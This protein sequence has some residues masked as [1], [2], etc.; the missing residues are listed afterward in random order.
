MSFDNSHPEL[1]YLVYTKLYPDMICETLQ[2]KLHKISLERKQERKVD[3]TA[4]HGGRRCLIE[5]QL[6]KS[7]KDHLKQV[8]DLIFM[9]G[10]GNTLLVW[11]AKEFKEHD[12][13]EIRNY[14]ALANGRNIEFVALRLNENIIKMVEQINKVNLFKQIEMLG[15]LNSESHF[16]YVESIKNYSGNGTV[17][18]E[19]IEDSISYTRKQQVLLMTI[20]ELR[21]DFVDYPNVYQYKDVKKGYFSIGPGFE[22]IDIRVVYNKK[23]LYG[24]EVIFAQFKT[25][26]IFYRLYQKREEISEKLDFLITSWDTRFQKIATYV[27]PLNYKDIENTVKMMA[28]IVKR[29]IYVFNEYIGED[30]IDN[31]EHID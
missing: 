14:I 16:S 4:Y 9:V 5:V 22:D 11:I 25:K 19:F 18:S 28:R 10:K 6:N 3:I 7:D 31:E 21:K 23:G 29:Y 17:S 8:K 30:L 1:L 20:K 12:L 26:Q 27:N 15:S 13:A 2:I 24:V